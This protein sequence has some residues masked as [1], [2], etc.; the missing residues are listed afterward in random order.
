MIPIKKSL[1][2][3]AAFGM[4]VFPTHGVLADTLIQEDP[5]ELWSFGENEYGQTGLGVS[6]DEST[7]PTQ[8]GSDEEWVA[9]SAG[10]FHTLAIKSDG[11]LWTFG[12]NDAGKTGLGTV[13]GN[14]T[15]PT[16]I[17]SDTDWEL[18]SAGYL[19]SLAIKSD[20]TLWSFGSNGFGQTGLNTTSG[21]TT[22][23]T[24][25]GS[26]TDWE[27]ASAGDYHSVA[28]K[29]DGT[30]W[31]FGFNNSGRTG[32]NTTSGNTTVPTQVGSDTDWEVASVGD[33][34]T[35][36][37]KTDGT[38]WSFGGN[39]NGRTGL[40]TDTGNTLVP[41]QVGV[42]TNWE[43]VSGGTGF[44][45]VLASDG[46]LWSFGG[47][48]NGRTGLNTGTGNTLVPTQVGSDT[49]WA[50]IAA[51]AAHALALKTNNSLWSFGAN[52]NGR[53]GLGITDGDTLV[54]TQVGSDTDW[55]FPAAGLVF[56]MA[57]KEVSVE[58]EVSEP[59][60]SRRSS[61]KGSVRYG[62]KDTTAINYQRF[63]SHKQSLCVYGTVAPTDVAPSSSIAPAVRN[64][65][66]G[67]T[68]EDVAML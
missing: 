49:D 7:E 20:G 21:N 51:G 9:V 40:N 67:M 43:A 32:L 50:V 13:V 61:S 6:V 37:I 16:Q 55:V 47:N 4:I 24:Q 29:S 56:S 44:A 54:P 10:S 2:L 64:L 45:L 22:V 12:S 42:A 58:E 14:T 17:G 41:T 39:T 1:L 3:A 53:T 36:A 33:A 28:I 63:S 18:V 8:V 48:T 26:D 52:E 15:V 66:V 11:T 65:E 68:G 38:L 34:H 5:S 46:T 62:C 23:P 57:L 27:L 25:I 30:L 35:L 31:S 19:H 60:N 59:E